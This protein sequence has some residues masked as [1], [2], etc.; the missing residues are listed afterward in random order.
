MMTRSSA[1]LLGRKIPGWKELLKKKKTKVT[2]SRQYKTPA[3]RRAD[4]KIRRLLS[5]QQ[6]PLIVVTPFLPL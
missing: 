3:V 2:R 4:A 5:N 1:N 6:P